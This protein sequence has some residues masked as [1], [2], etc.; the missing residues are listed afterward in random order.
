MDNNQ[1]M[2]IFGPQPLEDDYLLTSFL[3]PGQQ[4]VNSKESSPSYCSSDSANG[5]IQSSGGSPYDYHSPTEAAAHHGKQSSISPK[6][7]VFGNGHQRH[8][9][10]LGISHPGADSAQTRA[11]QHIQYGWKDSQH[12]QYPQTMLSGPSHGPHDP[13]PHPDP[14]GI[15]DTHAFTSMDHQDLQNFK[16]QQYPIHQPIPAS[17]YYAHPHIVNPQSLLSQQ[18]QHQELLLQHPQQSQPWLVAPGSYSTVPQPAGPHAQPL[19][20]PLP[21]E[22]QHLNRRRTAPTMTQQQPAATT[23]APQTSTTGECAFL[24]P[25]GGQ[26]FPIIAYDFRLSWRDLQLHFRVQVRLCRNLLQPRLLLLQAACLT[27]R[28]FRYPRPRPCP[29]L[30][31]RALIPT[32][33]NLPLTLPPS[34]KS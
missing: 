25:G 22:Q 19:S 15:S 4:D 1:Y 18:Q 24:R 16:F 32:E 28:R 33:S 10:S 13:Y 14:H 3:V 30:Y 9:P 5:S 8:N 34:M 12:S 29:A 31:R 21:S 26:G 11:V 17:Q 23:A 27:H 6:S 2:G 7:T 20:L